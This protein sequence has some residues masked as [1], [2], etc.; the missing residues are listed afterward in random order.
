MP[1][2]TGRD[3]LKARLHLFLPAVRDKSDRG[4]CTEGVN[5]KATGETVS[6]QLGC[7]DL[8]KGE[9]Q[10]HVAADALLLQILTSPDALPCG[11][12]LQTL[13]YFSAL[14]YA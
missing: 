11:C 6:Q 1:L 13:L 4:C 14:M 5:R 9:E 7:P 2:E 3:M 12:N 8:G 10:S